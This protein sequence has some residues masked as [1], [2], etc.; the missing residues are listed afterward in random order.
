MTREGQTALRYER[1]LFAAVRSNVPHWDAD[2][3]FWIDR[4]FFPNK[5]DVG[6]LI[7]NPLRPFLSI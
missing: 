3:L 7:L 2:D 5:N 1:P 6:N 4:R